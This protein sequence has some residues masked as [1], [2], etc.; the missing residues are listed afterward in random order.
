MSGA[1]LPWLRST[2][3]LCALEYALLLSSALPLLRDRLPEVVAADLPLDERMVAAELAVSLM[4]LLYTPVI[5]RNARAICLRTLAYTK[6]KV[7]YISCDQT[8]VTA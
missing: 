3:P 5:W 7:H 6:T 1:G 8:R 2:L 4:P